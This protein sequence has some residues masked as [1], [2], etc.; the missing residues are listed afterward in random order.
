[1]NL[2]KE[3]MSILPDEINNLIY[4]MLG[5][6]KEALEINDLIL[7]CYN[8]EPDKDDETSFYEWY[9][10]FARAKYYECPANRYGNR[11]YLFN[12]ENYIN[13]YLY[14]DDNDDDNDENALY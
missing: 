1:M 5:I 12:I 4:K 2:I 7:N 10:N 3:K 9:F 13:N 6:S 11:E 8:E 14:D